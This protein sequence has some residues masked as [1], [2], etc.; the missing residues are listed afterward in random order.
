MRCR[1]CESEIK[2]LPILHYENMPKAAQ[3]FPT[4]DELLQET[5]SSLSIFQCP[6]CGLIQILDKPVE[7]Y[8]DVIRAS[9]VSEEMR[10]FRLD[11]FRDFVNE[12]QLSGKKII[13]IGAGCGE[14]LELMN[15]TGVTAYGLEHLHQSVECCKQKGLAVFE[16]YVEENS[17]QIPEAPFDGFFIMNFLEHAPNPNS[18]LKG[19][20]QNLADDAVGLIEVPN[21]DMI[22][23]KTMFSEFISDHLL[24]FTSSTLRLMLEKNGFDV[25]KCIPVW[26]DYCLAAVVKKKKAIDMKRFY[27]VTQKISSEINSYIDSFR[28]KGKQ[29]VVWGAGHQALAV[30]ALS[31]IK[32][33][34]AF[35]VDSADFKQGKYTPGTHIKIVP[36][37]I[38]EESPDVGAVLVMAASYSDEVAKIIE[39]EYSE[40]SVAILRDYGLEYH[41]TLNKSQESL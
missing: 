34:I 40:L 3:N 24:Y 2:S 17:T 22:L 10:T 38:L 18:F 8:K 14:F 28:T 31:Q 25:L 21:V 35:V 32:D 39:H 11:Y 9:A 4:Q 1:C 36:P 5:G 12:Y 33:K 15:T 19:I 13:E 26:H 29:V 16:G 6:Y 37:A 7:Y 23:D 27:G 41:S 30:I 20:Y